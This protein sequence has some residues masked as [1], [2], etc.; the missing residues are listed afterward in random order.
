[1]ETGRWVFDFSNNFQLFTSF[2]LTFPTKMSMIY[3]ESILWAENGPLAAIN[4]AFW[5]ILFFCQ[6][7]F[8]PE[9]KEGHHHEKRDKNFS[10]HRYHYRHCGRR[11][12]YHCAAALPGPQKGRGRAG[13]LSGLLHPVKAQK[14]GP[15]A[16]VRVLVI[17]VMASSV[18]RGLVNRITGIR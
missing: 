14:S 1:M 5:Q 7:C 16:L 9:K 13:T 4:A 11:G 8:I 17:F 12:L 18:R 15:A 10:V 3:I 6:P 2:I